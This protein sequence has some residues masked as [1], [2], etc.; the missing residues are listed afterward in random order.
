M[1]KEKVLVTKMTLCCW[2]NKRLTCFHLSTW[3]VFLQSS[4]VHMYIPMCVAIK[5]SVTTNNIYNLFKKNI[6]FIISSV[7]FIE[8]RTPSLHY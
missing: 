3:S 5:L 7:G 8:S 6:K 1:T 4:Y 2:V